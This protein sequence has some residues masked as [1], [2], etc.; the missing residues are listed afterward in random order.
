MDSKADLSKYREWNR[1]E[2]Y[3]VLSGGQVPS[4][5]LRERTRALGTAQEN[6][7]S[8]ACHARPLRGESG[9]IG[10]HGAGSAWISPLGCLGFF[11]DF[12]LNP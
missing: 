12:S 4:A 9:S 6:L 2:G 10:V 5:V 3:C 11:G 7:A 1:G 8:G